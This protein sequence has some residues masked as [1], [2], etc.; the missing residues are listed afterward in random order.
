VVHVVD[1]S[2]VVEAW[3]NLFLVLGSTAASLI[4]LVFVAVSVGVSLKQP[5]KGLGDFT[6]QTIVNFTIALASC[7]VTLSPAGLKVCGVLL[8]V[9]GGLGLSYAL[10]F[11]WHMHLIDGY[12][13]V[14]TDW[15]YYGLLPVV[16]YAVL[17]LA[18]ADLF[19]FANA[20]IVYVLATVLL[21]LV[22]LCIR[23]SYELTIWAAMQ[24]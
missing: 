11:W 22:I 20:S 8:V 7:V 5:R 21:L 16:D 1:Q 15:L 9:V 10:W 18:A 12:E 6:S 17:T 2:R 14:K 13:Q 23:N 24:K 19:I 4:G 3:R